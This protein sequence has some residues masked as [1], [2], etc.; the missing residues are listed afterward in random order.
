MLLLV[1]VCDDGYS[2]LA[3][4]RYVNVYIK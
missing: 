1:N 3:S 2:I 4:Y